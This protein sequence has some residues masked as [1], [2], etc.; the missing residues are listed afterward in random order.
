MSKKTYVFFGRYSSPEPVLELM[1]EPL[2]CIA[3][4]VA[5]LEFTKLRRMEI[6]AEMFSQRQMCVPRCDR[7]ADVMQWFSRSWIAS[8]PFMTRSSMATKP[9]KPFVYSGIHPL[10]AWTDRTPCPP[11]GE[12]E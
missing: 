1:I 4:P 11:G 2:P 6:L 5:H 8:L 10:D 12:D 7:G 3:W 9:K